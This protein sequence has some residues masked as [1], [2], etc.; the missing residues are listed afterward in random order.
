MCFFLYLNINLKF[1]VCAAG[2]RLLNSIED[3]FQRLNVLIGVLEWS[4]LRSNEKI[5]QSVYLFVIPLAFQKRHKTEK[6]KENKKRAKYP[7]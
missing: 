2:K 4:F 6:S 5:I 3:S 7:I 1:E